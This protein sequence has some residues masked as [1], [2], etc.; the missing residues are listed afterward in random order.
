MSVKKNLS[1]EGITEG[2]PDND[3]R[4]GTDRKTPPRYTGEK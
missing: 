4:S 1:L 2:S 3:T